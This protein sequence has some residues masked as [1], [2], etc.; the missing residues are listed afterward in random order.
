MFCKICISKTN[1]SEYIVLYSS[2]YLVLLPSN[3]FFSYSPELI[4]LNKIIY[5]FIL[6]F[7]NL[8]SWKWRGRKGKKEIKRE[9]NIGFENLKLNL[10]GKSG[11]MGE[12]E[13][14]LQFLI[15]NTKIMLPTKFQDHILDLDYFYLT[16]I[17]Y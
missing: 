10:D 5:E 9:C 2:M 8:R 15:L 4:F 16:L 12:E 1:S 11:V 3:S 7:R 14:A 6:I 17:S 13:Y